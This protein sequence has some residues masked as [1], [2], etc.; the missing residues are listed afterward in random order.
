MALYSKKE[1]K[2]E[3]KKEKN[4]LNPS[5]LQH[6]FTHCSERLH[7]HIRNSQAPT[8]TMCKLRALFLALSLSCLKITLKV[9]AEK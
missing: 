1:G 4:L 3:R 5:S 8:H 7:T 9:R 2:K 6:I